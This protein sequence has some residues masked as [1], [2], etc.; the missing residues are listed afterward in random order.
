[1]GLM[2][3]CQPVEPDCSCQGAR[4]FPED[5]LFMLLLFSD[6]CLYHSVSPDSCAFVID[7]GIYFGGP[8]K[9]VS[10]GGDQGSVCPLIPLKPGLLFSGRRISLSHGFWKNNLTWLMSPWSY[11]PTDIHIYSRAETCGSS[12]VAVPMATLVDDSRLH[13][14]AGT[15]PAPNSPCLTCSAAFQHACW[16]SVCFLYSTLPS[17]S[18]SH[19]AD[20]CWITLTH[21]VPCSITLYN[22]SQKATSESTFQSSSLK[23]RLLTLAPVFHAPPLFPPSFFIPSFNFFYW[24]SK[25]SL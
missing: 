5:S 13:T 4:I 1:M 21:F 2:V 20:F 19:P 15:Y 12:S 14:C 23:Q 10:G 24:Q 16:T 25:Y 8:W 9:P 7:L 6:L 11:A 22:K 3:Y 18:K 17:C